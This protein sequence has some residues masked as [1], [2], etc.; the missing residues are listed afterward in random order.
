MK[1]KT[2]LFRGIAGLS[3][4]LLMVTVTGTNLLFTYSG[5]INNAMNVQ[6]TRIITTDDDE[7]QVI[8]DN[9][10]GTDVTNKQSALKVE[11]AVASE[12]IAQAEEGTV[13]LRNEN[14]ALPLAEGT[15]ITVFGNGSFHTEGT[16]SATAF[17]AIPA[18]SFTD[19]LKTALGADNVNLEL[20]SVYASLGTTSNTAVEEAPIADVTAKESSWAGDYNDAAVVMLSRVGSESNESAMFTE[21]GRRYLGLSSNEEDLLAYLA[22]EK[23]GGIFDRIIVLINADQ[24]MELDWLEQYDVDACMIVG[25]PGAVGFTGVANVL[26]GKVSPSGHLVDTYAANSLSAPANTY[27][28]ENTQKF[29]NSTW[30]NTAA[31]DNTNDGDN[32][33]WYVVY[34]EGIYVGY[35]YYETRYEDVVMGS[36]NAAGTAGSSTGN[37]WNYADEVC[38]PFGHGLSYTEF[39]QELTGV[40]Y[41]EASDTYRVNVKVT[42]SGSVAGKSVVEVYAQTPYGDYEKENLVEKASVQLVGFEK[43][44]NLAPGESTDLTVAVDRYFL[45]SYDENGAEGYILSA[46]DYYLAIGDDAHDALNNIL[47][48]KGYSAAEGMTAD[49]DAAKT[50]QWNQAELDTD[51]YRMSNVDDSV[52][53]TNQF[54]FADLDFYDVDFT[55]LSRNDW[56]GTYPTDALAIEANEKIVEA[57]NTDWY[58]MPADAPAVSDFTQGADNG[59]SFAEMVNVSWEDEETWNS[60]LDQLT[61]EEMANLMLDSEGT[62]GIDHVGMPFAGRNDDGNGIGSAL[63]AVGSNGMSWVSEVMTSRTWNKE[64]FEARGENLAIEAAYCGLTELWYGGGNIH[65]TPV[66]GRNNQYY[67]ED[68]NF[69]YFVGAYETKGMQEQGIIYCIK[70]FVLNDQETHREGLNTFCREQAL[71]ETYLR[72]FEGAITEGGANGVMTAFSRLGSRQCATSPELLTNVLKGEWGFKGHV[73]TDGYSASSLYKTHYLEELVSGLDY[74]CLD[75]TDHAAAVIAAINAGDGYILQCLRLAAKHNIYAISRTVAENGLNSDSRVVTVVPA[76]EIALLAVT[77]VLI[78]LLVVSVVMML[79]DL[80]TGGKKEETNATAKL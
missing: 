66:A 7:V 56:E 42:N 5:V 72:S 34:A 65:R 77:L 68:A 41:D 55:Y 18:V 47:A 60:F 39:T 24:M 59:L 20:E 12:N 54:D 63:T 35:K 40:E 28:G 3:A 76:W 2:V 43:T 15:R 46:G 52:E 19:S 78:I 32:I 61:V 38:Y 70:H 75:S 14:A 8:Y 36:G 49:G 30:L 22:E 53:V 67:S 51:S 1:K 27:A 69:G 37:A 44:K 4:F 50:Y 62:Q 29:T 74:S 45:A 21:E 25:L 58:V 23:A 6:T 71:R 64:R 48:A 13:L 10:Y 9:P 80:L 11:T 26:T 33:D 73:T 31:T 17:E 16:A 79:A 57:L